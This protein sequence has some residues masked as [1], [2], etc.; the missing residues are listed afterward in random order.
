MGRG[1]G[2][3]A[4]AAAAA[5]APCAVTDRRHTRSRIAG[6]SR[7]RPAWRCCGERRGRHGD[8][9]DS[10]QGDMTQTPNGARSSHWQRRAGSC[11]AA[12]AVVALSLPL[13]SP[14]TEC[15]HSRRRNASLWSSS[16]GGSRA[17]RRRMSQRIATDGRTDG[18]LTLSLLRACGCCVRVFPPPMY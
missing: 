8:G 15:D 3:G 14:R 17:I 2:D 12:A 18:A 9:G 4:A 1:S 16:G 7:K 11:S 13:T 6:C 10:Q 5:T